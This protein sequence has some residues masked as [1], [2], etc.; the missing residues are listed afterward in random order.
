MVRLGNNG[1]SRS[2]VLYILIYIKY[3][4]VRFGLF[5]FFQTALKPKIDFFQNYGPKPTVKA[6]NRPKTTVWFSFL[7]RSVFFFHA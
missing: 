2:N 4:S 1:R 6:K 5:F 3:S 7:C